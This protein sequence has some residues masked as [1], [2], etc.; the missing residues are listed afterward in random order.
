M[1]RNARAADYENLPRALL[2][3]GNTYPSGHEHAPH[4]HR[5]S[6]LLHAV[7]GTMVVS[8]DQGGWVV[9]PQQG[10][11]IPAGVTHGFRMIGEVSTRSVYVEPRN[12]CGLPCHCC[13]LGVSTLLQQLLIAAIDLPV[14][15]EEGSR[16]EAIATLI[17]HELRI[18][19]RR[20]LTLPFP[21]G[22][23]L[24]AKCIR[25][26]E[27]PSGGN[28]TDAWAN[29]LAMSRRSFTRL[30]RSETGLSLSEW[31]RRA[32]VLQ[33]INRLATGEAVTTIALDLGYSS[34]AAFTS[35]FTRIVAY[36]QADMPAPARHHIAVRCDDRFGSCVTSI[37]S[38]WRCATVLEMKEEP[39]GFG[40]Q[41]VAPKPLRLLSKATVVSV[42]EKP[43][44]GHLPRSPR[45]KGSPRGF[46]IA[47]TLSARSGSS[48]E[49]KNVAGDTKGK[50]ASGS[51]RE[52]ESTDT[53]ERGGLP[54]SRDEAPQWGWSG[55]GGSSPSIWANRLAARS[56]SFNGRRLPSRDGTR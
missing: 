1:V 33:A 13:V 30:F 5:R 38:T 23:S 12:D 26:L 7:T 28:A 55:G 34:P 54:R 19:S 10:L 45:R 8:T 41:V 14:S 29:E 17:L 56:P 4:A 51:N 50:G 2:A 25:F 3:V 37:A 15:Y 16:G 11:W 24:L 53:T 21:R 22:K 42:A 40:D 6:Q 49:R 18:A 27:R 47:Q 35:M 32:T 31:Q 9:P 43:V 44:S 52:A 36:R 20:P 39:S 48:A 46:D